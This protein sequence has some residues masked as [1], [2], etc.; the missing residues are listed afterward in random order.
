MK[1]TCEIFQLQKKPSELDM[2]E[3]I[4]TRYANTGG[5]PVDPVIVTNRDGAIS[6]VNSKVSL[7]RQTPK[8]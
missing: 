1:S 7:S 8:V 5:A 6:A 4:Y 3:V 2:G